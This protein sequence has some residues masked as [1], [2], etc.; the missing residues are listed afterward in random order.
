MFTR[1]SKIHVIVLFLIGLT[2]YLI[3]IAFSDNLVP[4]EE[5]VV[6]TYNV[7][8]GN[9]VG[10]YDW[11]NDEHTYQNKPS[12]TS[13]FTSEVE[14]RVY[15]IQDY[16]E[17][18][19]KPMLSYGII[20]QS[21]L[22]IVDISDEPIPRGEFAF[23]VIVGQKIEFSL[24]PSWYDSEDIDTNPNDNLFPTKY[25]YGAQSCTINYTIY[26]DESLLGSDTNPLDN[27][28]LIETPPVSITG[29]GSD[30]NSYDNVVNSVV[31]LGLGVVNRVRLMIIKLINWIRNP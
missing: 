27:S 23:D 30:D 14:G 4:I 2:F 5:G 20:G 3:P 26:V 1:D 16:I 11:D 8:T 13:V 18:G 6:V 10:I 9:Y 28:S 21:Y 29:N 17:N 15:F 25:Y 7:S 22:P 31:E 24:E 19:S 12:L